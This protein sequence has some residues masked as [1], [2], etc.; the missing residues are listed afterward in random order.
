[1]PMAPRV[2]PFDVNET[3]LDLRVL[4]QPFERIF[5]DQSARRD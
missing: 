2:I 1:M 5:G 4:D 3:L